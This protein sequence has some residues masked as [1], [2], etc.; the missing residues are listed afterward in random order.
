MKTPK[1]RP[2]G[3]SPLRPAKPEKS[4]QRKRP[5]A[6]PGNQAI[7]TK[8]RVN[9][10]GDEYERE[11][12]RV[13]GEVTSGHSA[14]DV[15]AAG[16]GISRMPE[17]AEQAKGK[18]PGEE[19]EKKKRV[20]LMKVAEKEQES[21]KAEAAEPQEEQK[22]EQK[23]EEEKKKEEETEVVQTK[24]V[25]GRVPE[26]SPELES[27]LDAVQGGGQPLPDS[28]RGPLE[29]RFGRDLSGVRVHTDDRA[30]R[31][32]D[33]LDAQAF[34]RGRDIFFG[35]GHYQPETPSGRHLLAHELTHTVQ[36]APGPAIDAGPSTQAVSAPSS[37]VPSTPAMSAGTVQRE[38]L[39]RQPKKGEA[40]PAGEAEKEA[41]PPESLPLETGRPDPSA[42]T[43][44]FSDIEVPAFK[45][46]PPRG[47]K[48]NRELRRQKGYK[49]GNPDQR[50]EW[51]KA[52]G[53]NTGKIVN[54]L[55]E[56]AKQGKQ[57]KTADPGG[58]YVFEAPTAYSKGTGKGGKPRVF[59]GDLSTIATELTL[60][61]WEESGKGH[62]YDVDHVLE[63][64]LANWSADAGGNDPSN[65]ELLDS[66]KNRSSGSTIDSTV[67]KK[68]TVFIKAAGKD[69][70]ATPAAIK[71]N[72]DLIFQKATPGGGDGNLKEGIDY[73][74]R[75]KIEAGD[76]LEPVRLSGLEALGKE[77][78]AAIFPGA[79][80]GVSKVF[81]WPGKLGSDEKNWI[82]PFAITEKTF[83]MEAGS[84]QDPGFGTLTFTL[85]DNPTWESVGGAEPI[86]V[87][88]FKGARYAGYINKEAIRKKLNTLRHKA[89]CPVLVQD[90]DIGPQGLVVAGEIH[91]EIPLIDGSPIS[92][93]LSGDDLTFAKTF[94][95]DEFK[96]PPPFKVSGASLTVSAGLKS[97][98]GVD[99][100]IDFGIDKLGTGYLEAAGGTSKSFS[101]KGGFDFDST[102][103]D[104]A[105]IKVSYV[106]EKF[107][108]E[109]EL[110][111]PEG[112]L[113]GVKK[114]T[115]KISYDDATKTIAASGSA[116]LSIP[117]VEKAAVTASYSEAEGL[118]LGGSV[119][120]AEGVPGLKS[121]SL[122]VQAKRDP[123][124]LYKVKAT[125]TAV[126]NIPGV[127]A[128]ITASYDDGL[129]DVRGSAGYEK[130]M[131]KG[132]VTVGATNRAVDAEGNPT[133]EPGEALTAYGGGEVSIQLA[134][135]LKG[136]VGL[137]L[138]PNGEIEVT[139][140]VAL[141][142]S[143]D[144]FPEKKYEKNLFSIGVD[145][146]IVGVSAAGQ[147]VGIFASV[148]GGLDLSAGIGPG[149]LQ[150]TKLAVQYNPDHEDQTHV[151]GSAK[152]HVP[153]HAGLR[154]FVR[155]GIGAGIPLVDATASLEVGGALALEGA[156][157]AGVQV[158]WTPAKGLVLD[159]FGEVYVEP[160]LRLDLS[161]VV[162]VELDLLV[163]TVELYS[164]RWTLAQFEYGSGM[165][166]G[167]K[168]PIHYEEG[169]SF[170]VSWDQVEFD[171]PD[172]DPQAILGAVLD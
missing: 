135:W 19:E 16:P 162:L 67:D 103:F 99:G 114:G 159:A 57:A 62:S 84:E 146:P 21:E 59:V 46:T 65:L 61:S 45:A 85:P 3:S 147:N 48:Y 121:G 9:Q 138:L 77:G 87:E 151:T 31:A 18:A 166:F 164:N 30:A 168:F 156:A 60:P 97:G 6:G 123:E 81:K 163:D 10:P 5:A 88:R 169:K 125:G 27:S 107:S 50:N 82:K 101:L 118:M 145:I 119:S 108:A 91:T 47:A 11:A 28:L 89:L 79:A 2:G 100:R 4:A 143:L 24:P 36:Q 132:S 54:K 167:V 66:S 13:A 115:V 165:R 53:Q 73:W 35:R 150:E 102:L 22:E 131:L 127:S 8:L 76:H 155:G 122:Q 171:T 17:A 40:A 15:S 37:T 1:S 134:P 153:A 116:D 12:D 58:T 41:V 105:S 7:Q 94:A 43:I 90:F 117:G 68:L 137:K 157:D 70:G 149:Q 124:G 130:G 74:T 52:V 161:A 49:R 152:L 104:P 56:K 142:S 110:G 112:K 51:K 120:L 113:K 141:P 23:D 42:K 93:E 32:A 39:Q 29:S 34:T 144:L 160:K 83:N 172:I 14:S 64:Q 69:Y 78:E 158:D 98:F 71:A 95:I 26:V 92:F 170:D 25:P 38:V 86:T 106:D 109:G 72:Y 80:G 55:E 20:E 75:E 63:L 139:G 129:F 44:T 128:T 148:R 96:F 33:N 140:E 133:G 111:I 136:T 126:P 154:L